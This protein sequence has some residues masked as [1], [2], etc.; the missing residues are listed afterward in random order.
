[1]KIML[2]CIIKL[3]LIGILLISSFFIIKNYKE[4]YKQEKI[5]EDLINIAENTKLNRT[6]NE[7]NDNEESISINK[8][9]EINPDIVAWIKIKDSNINY[10]VMQNKKDKY[11]YLRKDFYKNYSYWGTP[12]L[13]E[14]CNIET[15]SNLII[16]GHHINNSKL[17]G[18][19]ENYTQ[20][21][22]FDN[23]KCIE[24]YT[25]ND[26][27]AYNVFSVFKTTLN[28]NFQYYNYVD[29]KDE[30]EFKEF[31]ENVKELSIFEL[32]ENITYFDNLLILSTCDYSMKDGRLVVLAKLLK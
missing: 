28:S 24:I 11:F 10:P 25:M 22:Y 14:N 7:N 6:K 29:F 4:D 26:K 27:L 12:F 9:Y 23:H 13:S 5:F 15:S 1:M 32:E 2:K 16:Y 30:Y 3:L 19:L 17:F 18:E 20:K 31:I 21:S 8:L